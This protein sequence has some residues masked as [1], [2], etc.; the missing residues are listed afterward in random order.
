V[1]DG[2]VQGVGFRWF[3]HVRALELGIRGWVRNLE[4]GAVEVVGLATAETMARFDQIVRRGPPGAW[5]TSVT[6]DDVPHEAVDSK[7]FTIR[8]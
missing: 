8:H 1:V 3:I 4:N 6:A 5:V 2:R 7:S